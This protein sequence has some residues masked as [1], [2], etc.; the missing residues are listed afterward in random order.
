MS[1]FQIGRVKRSC[2]PDNT[3]HIDKDLS[4]QM[5]KDSWDYWES[6]GLD[7]PM[8]RENGFIKP[9]ARKIKGKGR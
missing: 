5:L 6:Q 8:K 9:V 3:K 4:E 7:H 1:E 2:G